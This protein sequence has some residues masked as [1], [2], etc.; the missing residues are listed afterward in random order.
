MKE[1]RRTGKERKERERGIKQSIGK[2]KERKVTVRKERAGKE[3]KGN[4]VNERNGK[5]KK[6]KEMSKCK[7]K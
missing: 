3:R 2:G 4:N 5:G 6:V 1:K 7:G